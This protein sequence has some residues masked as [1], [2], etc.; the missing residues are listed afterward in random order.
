[1]GTRAA[2]ATTTRGV[3]RLEWFT[4]I[5][6]VVSVALNYVDRGNLSITG[7]ALSKE[8]HLKPHELGFLLS[9]FFWTYSIFLVISGWLIERYNVVV[10]LTA[11]FVIWS[12]T[13]M[14]T[15][16]ANGFLSLFVLRLVLGISESVAYPS[17][18]KI[19]AASFSERHRGMANGLID[20]GCRLGP[21]AGLVGGGL[22][23]D[24]FGWRPV[25]LWIGLAGLAWLIPW[26]ILAP[27]IRIS[28]QAHARYGGPSFAEILKK[29]EAWGTVIGL[30]CGNYAWYFMLTW[31][32]QY[33]LTERGY[34]RSISSC[35]ACT[36]PRCCSKYR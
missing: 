35:V 1:M 26:C 21:A 16:F 28:S 11:G 4:L 13:T 3:T 12:A 19:L 23:L 24:R 8:L 7:V 9:G 32:P 22:I 33:L 30:F 25:F 2:A 5:L 14:L 31:L 20:V 34:S 36:D 10:V 15:G 17:Y 18:S 27:K 6:L 29:R